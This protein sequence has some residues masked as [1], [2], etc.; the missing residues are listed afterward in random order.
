MA[1]QGFKGQEKR[2]FP[3]LVGVGL[4]FAVVVIAVAMAVDTEIGI[5]VLILTVIC[6]VAALG[7]RV[8]AG[9][10]RSD[11]GDDADSS[12]NFPRQEA[13]SERPLGDTPE[14]HDE[15]SVHDLPPDNPARGEVEEAATGQEQTTRGPIQ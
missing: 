9:G 3:A 1:E 12:S 7:F 8:I 14:A 6:L 11:G 2:R 5:P 10:S 13:R 15:L 4:A